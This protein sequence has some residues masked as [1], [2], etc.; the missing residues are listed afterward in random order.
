MPEIEA[1]R[2]RYEDAALRLASM[3]RDDPEFADDANTVIRCLTTAFNERIAAKNLESALLEQLMGGLRA[4]GDAAELA[5]DIESQRARAA[6]VV[7]A[8]KVA[9]GTAV[10]KLVAE[11]L[12]H[13]NDDLFKAALAAG[14]AK[15]AFDDTHALRQHRP[16]TQLDLDL[17]PATS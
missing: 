14:Q 10:Q 3:A 12:D 6:E 17:P 11:V 4:G 7:L 13:G 1:A 15:V 16:V 8:A 5:A 2:R 9:L